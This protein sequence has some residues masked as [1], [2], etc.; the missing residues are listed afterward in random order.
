MYSKH[1]CRK[2]CGFVSIKFIIIENLQ[3]G[4]IVSTLCWAF[5][6][7]L[8]FTAFINTSSCSRMWWRTSAASERDNCYNKCCLNSYWILMWLK[9]VHPFESIH[10]LIL[11]IIFAASPTV[12][13]S[14]C[15]LCLLLTGA[16]ALSS[17]LVDNN[18]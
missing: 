13:W 16:Y 9:Y 7:E 17:F 14:V 2:I 5:E 15:D 10:C 18:H 6:K 8:S 3:L 11:N 4:G 12:T 1:F